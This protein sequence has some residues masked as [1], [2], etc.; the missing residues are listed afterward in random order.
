[1]QN[2]TCV[3]QVH[4]YDFEL[5][6]SVQGEPKLKRTKVTNADLRY[7]IYPRA[8]EVITGGVFFKYFNDPIEQKFVEGVGGAS[9]FFFKN[10]EKARAFGAELE[11]RKKLDLVPALK[12]FTFQANVSY[13]NSLVTDTALNIDRPLQGQSPYVINLGL[14]YDLEKQGLNMTLLFN[15]IGERIYLVGDVASAGAGVPDVYEAPRPVLDFQ[16]AK[17]L[18]K[19]KGEIKLN[20]SD[21]LN[22]TQYFYQNANANK[23]LSFQKDK[24]AYRFTRRFG[25]TFGLTFNYS[26]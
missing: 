10:A 15:Q 11:M 19:S 18:L 1:M 14:L 8:G 2:Q 17:K 22:R 6:A 5:N 24:D 4:L 21:L 16:V 12:N 26:L 25:T 9:T 13:I 3:F 23:N 7:E 20:I